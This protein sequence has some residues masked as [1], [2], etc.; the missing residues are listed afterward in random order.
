M[1]ESL[2][3]R[4]IEPVPM[5]Q[6]KSRLE[7]YLWDYGNEVSIGIAEDFLDQQRPIANY[8]VL[9]PVAAHQEASR[10]EHAMGEYAAQEGA[11]P[12]TIFLL[13]NYPY[14]ADEAAVAQSFA[15]VKRARQTYP[16]LDI[17]VAQSSYEVPIIGEVRKDLWDSVMRLALADG[18]YD[19]SGGE[20][21][22]INHD[23]DTERISPHYIRNIQRYYR[24]LQEQQ[25][26]KGLTEDPLP[27]RFTQ[28]KHAYPFATY[29]NIARAIFWSDFSTRQSYRNG[30]YEEGLVLPM[31]WY[32]RR[33]GFNPRHASYETR[34]LAPESREGIP[35]TGMDTSSRRFI[36]RLGE[37]GIQGI[38]S[39]GTFTSTDAC[40]DPQRMAVDISTKRLEEIIF[41][42]LEDD[43]QAFTCAVPAEQWRRTI[44]LVSFHQMIK[45]LDGQQADELLHAKVTEIVRP[46]LLLARRV[47]E[48]V[49]QS[50]NLA[51]LVDESLI[52]QHARVCAEELKQHYADELMIYVA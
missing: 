46:R 5:P 39:E 20:F 28:V 35:G 37:H 13:L 4:S 19:R 23:I 12:F 34:G 48:R 18:L 25:A 10:I 16:S 24:Q 47:L 30:I 45:R 9:I 17:R 36:E 2:E 1:I 42:H 14:D 11:D 3:A 44:N 8:G 26:A 43:L 40:R 22:G 31:S 52:A 15:A 32:A 49:V 29:P 50:P 6:R 27:A 51:E 38:W 41:E 7:T 21:I 33:G